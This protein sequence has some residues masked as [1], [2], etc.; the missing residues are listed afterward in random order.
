MKRTLTAALAVGTILHPCAFPFAQGPLAPRGA[1]AATV[2][3]LDQIGHFNPA[4]G[5]NFVPLH[6]SNIAT[7]PL[8]N[9]SF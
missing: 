5:A 9:I 4:S 7:N 1:P 8:A 2:K 6:S 3:A